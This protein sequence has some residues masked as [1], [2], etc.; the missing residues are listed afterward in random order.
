MTAQ[1]DRITYRRSHRLSLD[2]GGGFGVA[3]VTSVSDCTGGGLEVFVS[4]IG[5]FGASA[6]SV[7]SISRWW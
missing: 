5:V 7:A 2:S 1:K 6:P 4:S 3:T